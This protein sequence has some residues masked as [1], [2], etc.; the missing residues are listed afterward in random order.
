MCTQQPES[1]SAWSTFIK[2][3]AITYIE[4]HFIKSESAVLLMV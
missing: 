2:L 4:K 3:I 1:V